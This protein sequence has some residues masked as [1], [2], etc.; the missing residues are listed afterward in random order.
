MLERSD[1]EAP[2]LPAD[3]ESWDPPETP[4]D[5]DS[6]DEPV[7]YPS[8]HAHVDRYLEKEYERI[9]A[10]RRRGERL[11]PLEERIEEGVEARRGDRKKK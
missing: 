8:G 10:K 6:E 1:D 4:P 2:D 9:R 11:S 3:E 5:D 7:V